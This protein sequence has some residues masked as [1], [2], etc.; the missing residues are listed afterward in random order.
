MNDTVL[1]NLIFRFIFIIFTGMKQL[2]FFPIVLAIALAASSPLFAQS[3]KEG[4]T[5]PDF[6]LTL[7]TGQQIKLS[8]YKGKAVLL[9]FWATWC[10]PCRAELPEMNAFASK[11][12]SSSRIAFLAVCISDTEK[13]RDAFMKKNN[14]TFP[15]GLDKNGS[16]A[17]SY[18]IQGIPTSILISP[19]G[20]IEKIRVGAMNPA[21]LKRFVEKYAN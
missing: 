3:V 14:Y 2:N 8:D 18:F 13:S 10:G 16:I 1:L 9:H 20:K 12:D 7:S 6:S 5:A 19:D 21:E 15:G 4:N 17:A 11:L